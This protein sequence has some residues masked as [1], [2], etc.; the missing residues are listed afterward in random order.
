MI[1]FNEKQVINKDIKL[2]H[3]IVVNIEEYPNFLPWCSAARILSNSQGITTAELAITYLNIT[4]S[5]I[6]DVTEELKEDG[7][8]VI[9]MKSRC[10]IFKYMESYWCLMPVCNSSTLVE[11]DIK[12]KF[13]SSILEKMFGVF[14][15]DMSKKV[16]DSFVKRC[17]IL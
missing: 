13:S 17:H 12:F 16:V 6:S 1:H 3:K 11:F 15:H 14:F 8:I 7:C 10:G 9:S 4:K 2:L 5:F